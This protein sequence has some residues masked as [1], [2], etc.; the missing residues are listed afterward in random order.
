MQRNKTERIQVRITPDEVK[1]LKDV[2]FTTGV[3]VS[4]IVRNA[5]KK[6]L[7]RHK[8]DSIKKVV[9]E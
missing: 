6:E 2:S 1:E 5:V 3:P 9:K 4:T 8:A 7:K